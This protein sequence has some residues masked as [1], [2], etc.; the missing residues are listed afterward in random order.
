[1][2]STAIRLMGLWV[3][4]QGVVRFAAELSLGN[5]GAK[6][7]LVRTLGALDPPTKMV[8]QNTKCDGGILTNTTGG[9]DTFGL[10]VYQVLVTGSSYIG[11]SKGALSGRGGGSYKLGSAMAMKKERTN[12]DWNFFNYFISSW[13]E[14]TVSSSSLSASFLYQSQKIKVWARIP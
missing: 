3:V 1:M 4:V 13:N 5:E 9:C 7:N 12:S 8:R 11:N 14:C 6:E 10:C 2:Q